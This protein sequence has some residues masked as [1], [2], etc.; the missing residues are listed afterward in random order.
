MACTPAMPPQA[1][2]KPPRFWSGGAGEWSDPIRSMVPSSTARQRAS[3]SEALADRWRALGRHADPLHVFGREAQV[4]RAGF[5]RHVHTPRTRLG[6]DGDAPSRT[7]VHDVEPRACLAGQQR[8]S[9]DRLDFG[10]DR[11]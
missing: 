6:R 1:R 11:A 4:V 3:L 2:A 5:D 10:D 9:R 8:G 7:D